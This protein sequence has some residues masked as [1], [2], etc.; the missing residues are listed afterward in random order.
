MAMDLNRIDSIKDYDE[1]IEAL[2]AFVG[3][4]V[5]EF[6]ESPEGKAYLAEYP[7]MEEFVGSWIDNLLYFGYAY[8]S[9]TLP[10]MTKSKVEVILTELFPRKVSLM[11]PE[12]ANST[13]PELLAFWQYLKRQYKHRHADQILKF[14][15]KLQP[16]FKGIMNDSSKFGMAKSI[17]MAGVEA[18][19]DMTSPEGLKAFQEHHNQQ[20]RESHQQGNRSPQNIQNIWNIQNLD[21]QNTQNI[22]NIQD[23]SDSTEPSLIQSDYSAFLGGD[24]PLGGMNVLGG[25]IL[26]GNIF[27]DNISGDNMSGGNHPALENIDLSE[28]GLP[29]DEVAAL[30]EL[31]ANVPE[32]MAN[33]P[34]VQQLLSILSALAQGNLSVPDLEP[35]EDFWQERRSY[36]WRQA[37][38]HLEPLSAEAIALLQQ[39]QIT[40]TEPGKILQDFQTILEFVGDGILVSGANHL[41]PLNA[42]PELNDRLST[43][44]PL[45]LKRP[46]MKSFPTIQGLYLLLR[47]TGIGQITS[48][49]KKS[50]MVLE[51]QRL[52]SW[53]TL[54]PTERYFTLLEAWMLRAHEEML[55]ETRSHSDE[56]TKTMEFF[57]TPENVKR[58]IKNYGEQDKLNYYPEYH[59]LALMHLFGLLNWELG[60]PEKGKGFRIRSFEQLPWGQTLMQV[61]LQTSVEREFGWQGSNNPFHPFG[62]LQAAFQPYFPEW[63]NNLTVPKRE[64][65]SGVYI[66]KVSLGKIWR[67]LAVSGEQTLADL[68]QLIL[69]SVE[70]DS[71]HLDEFTYKNASGRTVRISHPYASGSPSTDQVQI[72]DLQLSVGASMLYVFDFGDWWEFTVQL[73]KIDSEDTRTNYAAILEQR[74]KAPEQYPNWDD[75]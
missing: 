2:E 47:A 11:T 48:K 56:G 21:T 7:E 12:D 54:N 28:L 51:P 34:E 44:I 31:M 57:Y 16:K 29:P 68:S 70:F 64:T 38:S 65:R 40:E 8:E 25:D 42:L 46:Q 55:G 17:L 30:S 20:I 37:A 1:A 62:E 53:N 52:Q 22:Q 74:G 5:A 15:Q 14:L 59:N 32:G 13:I 66:F 41:F 61:T 35:A 6:V 19:F 3:D 58:T 67:R 23:I 43:P 27:G 36:T 71:D 24:N 45:D 39:Q 69:E 10:R 33:H 75:E 4:L 9:V 26:S 63:Q 60:K 72:Q 73:E 49:G 50:I 18:G